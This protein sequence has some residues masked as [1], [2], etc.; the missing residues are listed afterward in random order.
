M[1]ATDYDF[2]SNCTAISPHC[3]AG[4]MTG[5]KLPKGSGIW[6]IGNELKPAN[7]YCYLQARFGNPNGL[8]NIFR[9]DDSDNLIHWEWTLAHKNGLISIMGMNM[10]SEVH[11]VGDWD[12]K[13]YSKEQFVEY[14][15][16]DFANYGKQMAAFRKD[17]L[18]HWDI[19]VNPYYD[20][21]SAITQMAAELDALDLNPLKD[22]LPNPS[23]AAQFREFA[24][25]CK[26]LMEKYNR[27]VGLAMSIRS[28][29]PVIAESFINLIIYLLCREDIK[30]NARLYQDFI[31]NNIDIKVQLLHINCI[32][33]KE[34][35]DWS[36]EPCANYNRIVSD[37]NDFLHGNINTDKQT[38]QD[39]FF[40]GKVPIFK[41][42]KTFWQQSI[43]VSIASSGLSEVH[44][45]IRT[46][47]E[48]ENYV[49]G[50]LED[51][52]EDQVRQIMEKRDLGLNRS[53]GR[54]GVL[55]P[56]HLVDFGINI[57]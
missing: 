32:G 13:N 51:G 30:V 43:G 49:L 17:C 45:G 11:L 34:Q 36:S 23:V 54:I 48:F 7:L 3:I 55:L 6:Q 22:E 40:R 24:D 14:V 18:E 1:L 5:G 27:G 28:L 47:R 21:N 37:R 12:F 26:A 42:Y 15:K 9:K 2:N 4:I 56:D 41:E 29:T 39:I 20:I 8:Q 46:I 52:L 57:I 10:R 19:F 31:R 16:R 25:R 33:F 35:V 50:R 38:F 44:N 53:T